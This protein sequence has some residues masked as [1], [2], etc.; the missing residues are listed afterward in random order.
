[1]YSVSGSLPVATPLV[2]KRGAQAKADAEGASQWVREA[3]HPSH[4]LPQ[5]YTA[6]RAH[7]VDAVAHAAL[8][9][10]AVHLVAAGGH[11]VARGV[12]GAVRPAHGAARRANV[13]V[14]GHGRLV[15]D[16]L[17]HARGLPAEGV[18]RR[19]VRVAA[20][21]QRG[22]VLR[23]VVAGAQHLVQGALVRVVQGAHQGVRRHAGRAC[24][25]WT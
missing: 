12:D 1:M 9:L 6:C 24:G 15:V 19:G 13:Q 11:L 7:L 18:L 21:R 2:C 3:A 10:C 22:D 14:V 8:E 5:A 16:A 23:G 4:T 20:R 25:Q 17:H